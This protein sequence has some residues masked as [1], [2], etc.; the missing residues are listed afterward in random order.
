MTSSYYNRNH[1]Y[2][3]YKTLKRI[4][5]PL[6]RSYRQHERFQFKCLK[7]KPQTSSQFKIKGFQ[8]T[9]TK[10]VVHC[11]EMEKYVQDNINLFSW[12]GS[13]QCFKKI[14]RRNQTIQLPPPLRKKQN[15]K[16]FS[17]KHKNLICSFKKKAYCLFPLFLVKGF[18][19]PICQ[20]EFKVRNLYSVTP[21]CQVIRLVKPRRVQ[22]NI[23]LGKGKEPYPTDTWADVLANVLADTRMTHY[24]R[25]SQHT[26]NA[27][28]RS[29]NTSPNM[30][31]NTLP[32][33]C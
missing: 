1:N 12:Y 26:T 18:S 11:L 28:V 30:S 29:I 25:I 23:F 22:C 24:Q 5:D 33:R 2:D 3:K 4:F 10:T 14:Q 21:Q 20:A 6:L 8:V 31:P 13:M 9:W 16:K 17:T 27:L 15:L 7:K 19:C 32:M